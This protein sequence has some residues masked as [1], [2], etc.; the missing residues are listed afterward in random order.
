VAGSCHC[1]TRPAP[2]TCP[3]C[4]PCQRRCCLHDRPCLPSPTCRRTGSCRRRCHR[5]WSSRC[6]RRARTPAAPPQRPSGGSAAMKRRR[7]ENSLHAL[8]SSCGAA[9]PRSRRGDGHVVRAASLVVARRV[10]NGSRVAP[11]RV[12]LET[13]REWIRGDATYLASLERTSRAQLPTTC[14]GSLSW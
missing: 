4:P 10:G 9:Y 1:R 5:C 13:A 14:V 8:W 6:R 11:H 3:R 7:G 12:P 2:P